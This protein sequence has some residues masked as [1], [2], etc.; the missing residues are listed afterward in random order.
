MGRL[1]RALERIRTQEATRSG[2]DNSPQR[3]RRSASYVDPANDPIAGSLTNV[4]LNEEVLEDNHILNPGIN[5]TV[6]TAYKM[7]RTRT[8]QRMRSNDWQ[9][10]AITS[11]TQGDGKS[12][13]AIN[14]A[15]SLA[16]DVNHNVCLV[17]LDL[18]HS[19]V[20]N[21]LGLRPKVGVSDCLARNVPVEDAL[22]RTNIDRLVVLPNVRNIEHSSELISS[23]AMAD[24]AAHLASDSNRIVIYDLPPLLAADDMLAFERFTDALL[25]VVSEGMTRRTDALKALELLENVNLIGVVLNRSD[26]KTAA[27]Y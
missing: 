14:L 24:L 21:Y 16:G 12:I 11:A 13:T 1:D 25:L 18:R 6:K 10:L 8:L 22:L 17:D 27:Y 26:E 20:A 5:P 23:P 15:I 3:H 7:L 4:R 19:S 9:V 2:G